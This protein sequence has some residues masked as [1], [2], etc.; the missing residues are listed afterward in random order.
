MLLNGSKHDYMKPFNKRLIEF[1]QKLELKILRDSENEK[2][3]KNEMG[4]LMREIESMRDRMNL[5]EQNIRCNS[6]ESSNDVTLG[7]NSIGLRV[8][9]TGS[10]LKGMLFL[11]LFTQI[12]SQSCISTFTNELLCFHPFSTFHTS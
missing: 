1:D 11:T 12:F 2:L 4:R 8:M 10:V 6:Y 7:D 9:N 5:F 3:M